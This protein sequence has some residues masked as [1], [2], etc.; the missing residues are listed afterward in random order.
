MCILSWWISLTALPPTFKLV[1]FE[2]RVCANVLIEINVMNLSHLFWVWILH[3]FHHVLASLIVTDLF[4]I[5]VSS[6]PILFI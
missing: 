5:K 2:S 6:S 1:E 4:A 3:Y